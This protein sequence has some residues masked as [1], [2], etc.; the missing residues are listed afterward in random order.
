MTVLNM[1]T[2]TPTAGNGNTGSVQPHNKYYSGYQN[3]NLQGFIHHPAGFPIEWRYLRSW[4]KMS[5][6]ECHGEG[7]MGL[8]FVSE[9]Y[10]RPGSQL[11]RIVEQICH[12]EVYLK[13]KRHY[14]GPFISPERVARE[15][16]T[17]FASSFPSFI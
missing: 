5:S 8:C 16:V 4:K 12:I 7:H 11:D 1:Q 13:H 2:R 17:R 14:E 15:W 6:I 3:S 9:Q 10:I